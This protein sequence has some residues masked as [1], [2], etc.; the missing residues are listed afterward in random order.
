MSS[1][2]ADR[3]YYEVG[4]DDERNA[5][6]FE[7]GYLQQVA[8]RFATHRRRG[9]GQGRLDVVLDYH[10]HP[11]HLLSCA[12][13]GVPVTETEGLQIRLGRRQKMRTCSDLTTNF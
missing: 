5:A 2:H 11:V 6:R 4:V 10:V 12:F 1:I 3:H 9:Q 13:E 7:M 8:G